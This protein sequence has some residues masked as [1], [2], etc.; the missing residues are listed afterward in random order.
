[1]QLALLCQIASHIL[2]SRVDF[3][4]VITERIFTNC[5]RYQSTLTR[6]PLGLEH[7]RTYCIRLPRIRKPT[8]QI[9]QLVS[10]KAC[11]VHRIGGLHQLPAHFDPV[12]RITRQRRLLLAPEA[13]Q[14]LGSSSLLRRP[15]GG[16]LSCVALL[17]RYRLRRLP[18]GLRP[19]PSLPFCLD[20]G[21]SF[22]L[23]RCASS[24][25]RF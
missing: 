8:C 18:L 9:E 6:G 24:R 22:T 21:V 2:R 1:M 20:S 15:V 5:D 14:G 11:A 23:G 17:L 19:G 13:S 12:A 16:A 10:P 3:D 25:S 4:E 7:A